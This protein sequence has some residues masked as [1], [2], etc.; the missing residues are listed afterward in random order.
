MS[1]WNKYIGTLYMDNV[2]C[3]EWFSLAKEYWS[4]PSIPE[5]FYGAPEKALFSGF[6][7]IALKTFNLNSSCRIVLNESENGCLR[8]PWM[9]AWDNP[10]P[11]LSYPSRVNFSLSW[12]KSQATVY[13]EGL[14]FPK[15]S[16]AARRLKE[17]SCLGNSG[18]EDSFSH[19][20]ITPLAHLSVM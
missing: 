18:K 7:R 4:S 2:L 9:G 12:W 20:C 17:L 5:F 19:P 13:L 8:Q 14:I 1:R 3:I 15:L 11:F 10:P 6:W 16:W